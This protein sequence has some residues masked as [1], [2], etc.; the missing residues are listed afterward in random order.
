MDVGINRSR[1]FDGLIECGWFD[2]WM[3]GLIKGLLACLN[4]GI[5]DG[6]IGKWG[7]VSIDWFISVSWIDRLMGR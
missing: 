5:I 3:D 6:F 1:L 2:G 4:G 7:K